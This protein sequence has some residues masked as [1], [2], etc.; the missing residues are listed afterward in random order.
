MIKR[1]VPNRESLKLSVT[2]LNTPL[3]LVIKLGKA[4]SHLSAART[5]SGNYNKFS[6]CL[7]VII[8]AVAFIGHNLRNVI[9]IAVD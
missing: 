9:R 8:L 4:G 2:R 3:V 6:L 5:R 1:N 7:D